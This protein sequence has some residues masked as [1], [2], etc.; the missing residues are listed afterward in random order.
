MSRYHFNVYNGS[1]LVEDEEGRELPDLEIVAGEAL[2]GVRS[3]LS[4]EVKQGRL[5]LRGRLEVEDG[6]GT[7]VLT[8]HFK[9]A[10]EIL[11]G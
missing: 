10:I 8:L 9:E 6:E 4:D 3:I 5:D 7:I 11:A 2:K 1:G